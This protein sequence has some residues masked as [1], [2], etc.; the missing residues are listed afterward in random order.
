[1]KWYYDVRKRRKIIRLSIAIILLSS[2]FVTIKIFS[3]TSFQKINATIDEAP[4]PEYTPTPAKESAHAQDTSYATQASPTLPSSPT[5]QAVT[6]SLELSEEESPTPAILPTPS[7]TP[8][9][10]PS[11]TPSPVPSPTPSLKPT[12]TASVAPTPE[13]LPK[14]SATSSNQDK[15]NVILQYRNEDS[16]AYA[17]IIYPVFKI[18]N[19]GNGSVRLSD[20]SLRYY[21]TK[22]GAAA[23]TYWCD[24][25]T[26]SN[27]QV[28]GRFFDMPSPKDDTDR[29]LQLYLSSD[30]DSLEPG[31]S[32]EIKIGFSKNDWT[33]YNQQN[34]YSFKQSS[35]SYIDWS[36]V[37]LYV[38][39]R[40]VYGNE[41]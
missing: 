12:A 25:C 19:K 28:S 16:N 39:G 37:T 31:E 30:T 36:H 21:Y 33:Q 18:V 8:S 38:S 9:P 3:M 17:K 26:K 40:L 4:V 24:W 32:V 27:T 2:L 10:K 22:E 7:Y 29:Y 14:P 23:E 20:I 5:A 41:P 35:N 1:M 11:S 15:N 6:P 13:N 34:D